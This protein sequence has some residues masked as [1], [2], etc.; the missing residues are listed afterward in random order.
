MEQNLVDTLSRQ[1]ATVPQC[2][3]AAILPLTAGAQTPSRRQR[4]ANRPAPQSIFKPQDIP[5][6]GH[7]R[8]ILGHHYG[9]NPLQTSSYHFVSH[10]CWPTPPPKRLTTLLMLG[11]R[12]NWLRRGAAAAA[13]ARLSWLESGVPLNCAA[14]KFSP[15]AHPWLPLSTDPHT[16]SDVVADFYSG[17]PRGA[18][19]SSTFMSTMPLIENKFSET[20]HQYSTWSVGK[21]GGHS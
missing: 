12:A 3:S 4:S 7:F 6:W 13:A 11:R 18:D 2:W 10:A 20:N 1:V 14:S 9:P 8:S 5:I 16:R 17:L 21:H 15:S 19:F